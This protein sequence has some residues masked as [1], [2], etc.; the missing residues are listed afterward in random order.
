MY[1][2]VVKHIY[3]TDGFLGLYRGVGPRILSGFVGNY[4]DKIVLKVSTVE[5]KN[6][7]NWESLVINKYTS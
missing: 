2:F 6:G 7:P 5:L 3:K 1:L 4:V